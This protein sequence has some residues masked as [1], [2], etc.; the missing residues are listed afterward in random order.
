MES[1]RNKC[2]RIVLLLA[3]L[4]GLL[5]ACCG[6]SDSTI[7]NDQM[8]GKYEAVLANAS[9]VIVLQADGKFTE[10]LIFKDGTN[11]QNSGEWKLTDN[12]ISLDRC[13]SLAASSPDSAD[14]IPTMLTVLPIQTRFGRVRSFGID[15]S[16]VF[17][18][19]E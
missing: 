17:T 1:M 6:C 5:A 18:K 14:Y 15:E 11:R 2:P 3:S 12:S 7:R 9:D 16:S 4:A 10:A 19:T 13:F 8:V